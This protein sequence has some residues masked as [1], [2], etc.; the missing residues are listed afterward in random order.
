MAFLTTAILIKGL[1]KIVMPT[2]PQM[3]AIQIVM[4]MERLTTVK[5]IATETAFLTDA[6]QLAIAISIRFLT[7]ARIYLIAI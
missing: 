1:A 5:V 4:V 3:N 7:A 6:R 2:Q